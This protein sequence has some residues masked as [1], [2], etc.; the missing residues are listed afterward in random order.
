MK[1]R[2]RIEITKRGYRLLGHYVPGLI[3]AKTIAASVDALSPF[4]TVWFS[5]R[6][7]SELMHERRQERI[8]L[9]V[10]LVITIHL[11]FSMIK[12]TT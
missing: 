4:V 11:L 2:Q 7:I 3:K 6:I 9:Y 1:L 12:I 8:A 10:F 5:A